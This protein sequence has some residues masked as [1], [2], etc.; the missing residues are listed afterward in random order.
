MRWRPPPREGRFS[1]H[2]G[3]NRN[4]ACHFGE[5]MNWLI[6]LLDEPP[7]MEGTESTREAD[8]DIDVPDTLPDF[9][10]LTDCPLCGSRDAETCGCFD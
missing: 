2:H 4:V 9:P 1:H 3:K 7:E 6:H 10:T 5:S 8:F